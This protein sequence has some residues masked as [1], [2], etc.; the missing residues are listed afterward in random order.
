MM[1]G[2]AELKAG[3]RDIGQGPLVLKILWMVITL[4]L[5]LTFIDRYSQFG[6]KLNCW[7]CW[8]QLG[9]VEDVVSGNLESCF[10]V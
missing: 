5:R 9:Y 2:V 1:L 3:S 6:P 8:V 4:E 7:V 10:V